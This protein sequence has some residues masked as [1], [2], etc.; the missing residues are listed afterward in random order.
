[1]SSS[2]DDQSETIDQPTN[3]EEAGPSSAPQFV[4]EGRSSEESGSAYPLTSTP[5]TS[6]GPTSAPQFVPD[7]T[8][9]NVS[10]AGRSPE[11]STPAFLLT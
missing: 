4:P 6:A 2:Q 3:D 1:M 9:D 7:F 5:V 8:D 11:G 10:V